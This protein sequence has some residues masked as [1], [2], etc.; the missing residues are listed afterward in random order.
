MPFRHIFEQL[1]KDNIVLLSTHIVSDI[2]KC[3]DRILV[4]KDGQKVF[5]GTEQE[6][7]WSH[8]IWI[9]SEVKNNGNFILAE[10]TGRTVEEISRDTERDNFMTAGEALQYGLI[11]QVIEKR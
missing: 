5:D 4:I 11:D 2:E 1:G 8:F 9:Y 7:I 6:K 10:N 3:A